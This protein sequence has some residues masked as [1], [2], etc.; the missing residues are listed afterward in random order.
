MEDPVRFQA[1]IQ[2]E[3]THLKRCEGDMLVAGVCGE[4]L[5]LE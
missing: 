3:Q 2:H 5:S 1:R 4:S